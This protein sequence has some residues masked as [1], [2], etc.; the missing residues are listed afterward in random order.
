[1]KK[2][3]KTKKSTKF[4]GKHFQRLTFFVRLCS[5]SSSLS[6]SPFLSLS[7][8]PLPTLSILS[9]WRECDWNEKWDFKLYFVIHKLQF[10]SSFF[11]AGLSLSPLFPIDFF[12]VGLLPWND[13]LPAVASSF[14]LPSALSGVLA[15]SKCCL[16]PE[17]IRSVEITECIEW[18]RIVTIKV[19]F[20]L[21]FAGGREKR[22]TKRF[23][24][25]FFF[26]GFSE[27]KSL[28]KL[29]SKDSRRQS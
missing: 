9:R 10:C 29:E 19:I 12:F 26:P 22:K 18:S 21:Q 2:A 5:S 3:W 14:P 1:M 8:F 27:K 17:E 23:Q 16:Y 20:F 11:L 4:K 6:L 7:L 28:S 24:I 15:R 25:K 13:C